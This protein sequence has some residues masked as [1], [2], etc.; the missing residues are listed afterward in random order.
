[1]VRFS[2]LTAFLDNAGISYLTNGIER[3]FETFSSFHQQQEQSISWSKYALVDSDKIQ[4]SVLILPKEAQVITE[5]FAVITVD[6]PRYVFSLIVGKFFDHR[7]FEHT[8]SSKAMLGNNVRIGSNVHIGEFS[9]IGHDC[10]IGDNTVIYP[11]VTLYD[12][13]V[14]GDNV[15]LHSGCVIGKDGFGIV[16]NNEGNQ[17]QFPQLGNVVIKNNVQIGANTCIDR[18]TI[19]STVIGS[20]TVIANHCQIAHN[21]VIGSNCTITGKVQ[22]NGSTIIGDRVY[23]GPSC[24]ISNKLRIGN[25]ATIKIGAV[26]IRDVADGEIVS[27]HYAMSHEK[28]LQQYLKLFK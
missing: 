9:S 17:V 12:G 11:N 27:G 10:T 18:A 16:E 7:K 23:L 4:C 28:H 2:D 6:N 20:F 1:M 26:A 24:V 5:R 22:V 3:D 19:D 21:V 25:N 14:I 8:V 13:C 15:I